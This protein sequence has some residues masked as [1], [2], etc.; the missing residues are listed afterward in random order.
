MLLL[1]TYEYISQYRVTNVM[2]NT[3]DMVIK[4]WKVSAKSQQCQ[5]EIIQAL[6]SNIYTD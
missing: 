4:K 5:C 2:I 6:F 3:L 1:N